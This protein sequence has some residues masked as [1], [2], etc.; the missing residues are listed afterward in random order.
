MLAPMRTIAADEPDAVGVVSE[1]LR[2]G[3]VVVLPTDT[4]YGLA[5]A[6]TATT[7]GAA[8]ALFA[9]KG[10]PSS[11]PLAVLVEDLE[12]ALT[13]C[14]P[15]PSG[16]MRVIERFWPGPLTVVLERRSSVEVELG[17]E[18]SSVGVR[19]PDHALVRAVAGAVG[20]LVTTSA[21]RHGE[22]TPATASEV[23]E[24]FGDAVAV[25]VDGGRCDGVASTVIDGREDSLPVLRQGPISE[26]Q[27]RGALLR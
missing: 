4:V 15:P 17:G 5:V 18:G 14:E 16:V 10:R 27:I 25:V 2:G 20:P 19:S 6:A 22:Q 1:A 24:L 7:S 9:L 11:V 3:A 13:L 8:S 21:N 12:Q 23:A 26:E